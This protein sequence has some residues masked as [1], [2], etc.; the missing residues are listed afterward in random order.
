MKVKHLIAV[1]ET[2]NPESEVKAKHHEVTNELILVE[3]HDSLV[4]LADFGHEVRKSND[5]PM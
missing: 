2:M 3:V 4:D 5:N 1:L